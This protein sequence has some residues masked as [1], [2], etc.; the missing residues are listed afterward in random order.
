MLPWRAPPGGLRRTSYWT[1]K[2]AGG[3][4]VLKSA[5]HT[6]ALLAGVLA[7]PG[8]AGCWCFGRQFSLS[9]ARPCPSG[10]RLPCFASV[11]LSFC[12][13]LKSSAL[14]NRHLWLLTLCPGSS[15]APFPLSKAELARVLPEG[16]CRGQ[17]ALRWF[18]V[19]SL[20]NLLEPPVPGEPPVQNIFSQPCWQRSGNGLLVH[21][22]FFAG[23]SGQGKACLGSHSLIAQ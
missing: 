20:R 14:Q 15:K 6:A 8:V 12:P 16:I 2:A 11:L 21:P 23:T 7:C 3:P 18:W 13:F 10:S 17:W 19:S 22:R 5:L 9:L 1:G 4:G